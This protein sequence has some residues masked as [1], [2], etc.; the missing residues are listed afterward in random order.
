MAFKN[1]PLAST[2]AN[3][4]TDLVAPTASAQ[5]AIF[6][7]QLCNTDTTTSATVYIYLTNSANTVLATLWKLTIDPGETIAI[8]S[9]ITIPASTTPGK[10]RINSTVA[11]VSFCAFGS[12]G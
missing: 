8:D 7:I 1:W 11:A 12:E 2:T 6:N 5:V 9:K 3:T 10:I 4:V